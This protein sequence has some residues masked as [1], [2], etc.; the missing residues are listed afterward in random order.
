M[1]LR[2]KAFQTLRWDGLVEFICFGRLGGSGLGILANLVV[3]DHPN[4]TKRYCI[5]MDFT[6]QKLLAKKESREISEIN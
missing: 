3:S 4:E 2:M 1:N 6:S 5:L